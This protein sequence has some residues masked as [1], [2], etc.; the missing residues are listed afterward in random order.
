VGTPAVVSDLPVFHELYEGAVVYVDPN[1]PE[2]IG[3]GLLQVRQ[4]P[5]RRAALLREGSAIA[6]RHCWSYAIDQYRNLLNEMAAPGC[7]G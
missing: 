4:D 1:S 3:Q 6:E 7:Q 5:A 2:S